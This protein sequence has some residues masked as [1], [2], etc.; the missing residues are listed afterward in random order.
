MVVLDT[1]V[2]S[3]MMGARPEPQVA[4]WVAEQA[5]ESLFTTTVCQAEILSG[6][7][8]LPAGRRR[9]ALAAAAQGMF[10]EDFAGRL[11]PFDTVAAAANADMFAAR[12]QAGRPTTILDLMIAAIARADSA[13]VVTRDGG[14]FAGCGVPVVDPWQAL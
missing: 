13:T 8:I 11:L 9:S 5:A 14:G 6:I 10:D 7:A 4:A 3:A 2:L 12:R 1:N